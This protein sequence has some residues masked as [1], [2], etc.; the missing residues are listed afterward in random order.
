MATAYRR[1][2]LMEGIMQVGGWEGRGRG[3]EGGVGDSGLRGH[4]SHAGTAT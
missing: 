4:N 2:K 1:K 3:D